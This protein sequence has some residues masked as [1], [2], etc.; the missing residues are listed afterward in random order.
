MLTITV[1]VLLV[2]IPEKLDLNVPL[3]ERSVGP[4][5]ASL[6]CRQLIILMPC[7]KVADAFANNSCGLMSRGPQSPS[8][9]G[10]RRRT[11]NY[12]DFYKSPRRGE[13]INNTVQAEGAVP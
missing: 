10:I 13:T 8:L 7:A 3:M 1:S 4:S 9:C 11:S 5:N 6:R 2:S 12:G